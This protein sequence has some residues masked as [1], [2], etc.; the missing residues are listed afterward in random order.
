MIWSGILEQLDLSLPKPASTLPASSSLFPNWNRVKL[1]ILK[2][3]STGTF[4][5]IQYYAYT[6]ICNNFPLD[7]KPLF[8]SSIV[9]E[10]WES[11]ISTRKLYGLSCLIAL[12]AAKE[13]AGSDYQVVCPADE[14]TDDY[15]CWHGVPSGTLPEDKV[16]LCVPSLWDSN[17]VSCPGQ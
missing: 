6:A 2:L 4:I 8:T 7:P 12:I 13:T 1:A 10:E 3:I 17:L 15:E 14:L 5:D 16:A 9:I 11:A